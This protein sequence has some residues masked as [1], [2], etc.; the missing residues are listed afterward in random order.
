MIADTDHE[1]KLLEI[2]FAS[3]LKKM[4]HRG[5]TKLRRCGSYPLALSTTRNQALVAEN[6]VL[7][8]EN[9][10]L[11][12]LVQTTNDRMTLNDIGKCNSLLNYGITNICCLCYILLVLVIKMSYV[13]SDQQQDSRHWDQEVRQAQQETM[14]FEQE[15]REQQQDDREAHQDQREAQQETRDRQQDKRYKNIERYIN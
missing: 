12:G 3:N 15:V 5:G 6:G 13:P 10:Y 1:I 9:S 2:F 7:N 14:A 11:K 8:K 4:V